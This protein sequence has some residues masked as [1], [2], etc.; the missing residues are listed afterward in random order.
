MVFGWSMDGVNWENSIIDLQERTGLP[1]LGPTDAQDV[2]RIA[3]P[4]GAT[5]RFVRLEAV[6]PG[7]CPDWHDAASSASWMFLDELVVHGK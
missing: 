7:P 6:N 2:V 1:V 5:A 3:C 4:V